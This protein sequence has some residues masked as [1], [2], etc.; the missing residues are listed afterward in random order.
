[1]IVDN[2]IYNSCN[3]YKMNIVYLI[4]YLNYT[5]ASSNIVFMINSCVG[6]K[7][8][9]KIS[10]H[11][12]WYLYSVLKKFTQSTVIMPKQLLHYNSRVMNWLVFMRSYKMVF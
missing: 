11:F 6:C 12:Y 10:G 2:I 5:I 1:M 7:K 4:S 9:D 8:K 3:S